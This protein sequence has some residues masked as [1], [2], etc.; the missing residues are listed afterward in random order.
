MLEFTASGTVSEW[1]KAINASVT[2]KIA[3]IAGTLPS[4]VNITVVS[5]PPLGLS[6]LVTATIAV[7]SS[8]TAVAV[9]DALSASLGSAEDASAALGITVESIEEVKLAGVAASSI[10]TEEKG[11]MALLA[12]LVLLLPML[13]MVYVAIQY[14]GKERKYLSYRFSHTN[15]FVVVGYMPKERRDALWAEIKA[16][17][18]SKLSK[19][20]STAAVLAEA[21]R[22][23]TTESI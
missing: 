18:V 4:A 6:V 3:D 14:S 1:T 9:M 7:P 13:C 22:R 8:T 12:L 23:S 20:Q 21:E 10:S 19:S 15:P 5:V 11:A 17:K 2:G 16:P